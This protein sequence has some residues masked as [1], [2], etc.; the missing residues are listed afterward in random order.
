MAFL[1]ICR[2][3]T[4]KDGSVIL[5]YYSVRPGLHAIVTGI[6]ILEVKSDSAFH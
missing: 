4:E 6:V 1:L 5:H 3:Y 2:C